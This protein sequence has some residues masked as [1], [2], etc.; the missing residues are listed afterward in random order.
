MKK[1]L[2]AIGFRKS[3]EMEK[4]IQ[5]KSMRLACVYT[6]SF[7]LIWSLYG[8]YSGSGNVIPFI[9]F[10]SQ[11]LIIVLS[12][13]FFRSRMTGEADEEKEGA[14]EKSESLLAR[15]KKI[16]DMASPKVVGIVMVL[17]II[18][19]IVSTLIPFLR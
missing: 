15:L 6:T 4:S 1:M 11:S 10:L 16:N 19:L 2:E 3:D 7:L 8:I 13:L 9:L 12:Q 14:E 17:V 18:Y 5:L